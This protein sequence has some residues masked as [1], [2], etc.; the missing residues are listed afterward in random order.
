ME[1][2]KLCLS[3]TE[4]SKETGISLSLVRKLTHNGEIPHIKVGRRV[5]YPVSA[6]KDWLAKN[7]VSTADPDKNGGING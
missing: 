5:L 6:L 4:I 3:A 1:K 7:T 2:K